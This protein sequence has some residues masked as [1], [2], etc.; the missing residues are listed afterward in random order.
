MEVPGVLTVVVQ[1]VASG[2]S[3]SFFG[4]FQPGM[5]SGWLGRG[6]ASYSLEKQ[7][8]P[9]LSPKQDEWQPCPRELLTLKLVWKQRV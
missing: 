9:T 2:R 5:C 4:L 6:S 8:C 7:P 3:P 1:N